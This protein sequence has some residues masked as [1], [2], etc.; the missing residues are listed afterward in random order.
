MKKIRQGNT[1]SEAR[2]SKL[3]SSLNTQGLSKFDFLELYSNTYKELNGFNF[4]KNKLDE[5]DYGLGK[6]E[7]REFKVIRYQDGWYYEGEVKKGT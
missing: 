2:W 7:D 1:C 3:E 5:E 6:P 4:E